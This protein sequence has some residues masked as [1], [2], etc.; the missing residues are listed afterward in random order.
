MAT[1]AQLDA[2]IA[3]TRAGAVRRPASAAPAA[4]P[5]AEKKGKQQQKPKQPQQPKQVPPVQE[6][7]ATAAAPAPAPDDPRL[8]EKMSLLLSVGEECVSEPELRNLINKK[9]AFVLYDGFEPSGRM[10]IAQGVFKAMNVNKCTAAGG[11]FIFWVADW[12]ALM[13]DKMGGDLERIKLVGEYLIEVWTAAGMDMSRVEF[14][15]AAEEITRHAA[16]YWTLALDVA[17]KFTVARIS[18]CCQIMGRLEGTLTA[19]RIVLACSA[20]CRMER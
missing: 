3:E 6:K 8:A 2:I 20:R 12:F 5:P 7:Q 19:V 16:K 14:K 11:R 13:N 9:P 10:H 1:C 15:W 18:K 17:R 4:A